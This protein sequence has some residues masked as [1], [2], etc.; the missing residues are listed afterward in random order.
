VKCLVCGR[1]SKKALCARH[2]LACK[3]LILK[4]AKWKKAL[5]ISWPNY[6][7]RLVKSEEAGE[8][9]K[10]VAR[11]LLANNIDLEQAKKFLETRQ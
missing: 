8:W 10:Q 7:E 6:L 3:K 5:E 4:Y 2:S 1:T 11:Y 9:V